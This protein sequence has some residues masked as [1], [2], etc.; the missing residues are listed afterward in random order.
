MARVGAGLLGVPVTS[1]GWMPPSWRGL[2]P[3]RRHQGRAT[4]GG[5]RALD[6]LPLAPLTCC[7]P[8][9]TGGQLPRARPPTRQLRTIPHQRANPL[10][11]D[12]ASTPRR[13]VRAQGRRRPKDRPPRGRVER[14][15][16]PPPVR[17][18]AVAGVAGGLPAPAG[19]LRAPRGHS[20]GL[21]PSGLRAYLPQVPKRD[22]GMKH[23]LKRMR[24]RARSQ[25][26]GSSRSPLRSWRHSPPLI[27]NSVVSE[28]GNR[29]GPP[30]DGVSQRSAAAPRCLPPAPPAARQER[31]AA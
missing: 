20:A 10:A 2:P 19:P 13:A 29:L 17:G 5:R 18:R 26:R 27:R 22:A 14:Q 28:S 16:G 7:S 4:D 25:R 15:A 1:L 21:P 31:N 11:G 23:A 3:A 30:R 24:R 9:M 8:R 6:V 12:K